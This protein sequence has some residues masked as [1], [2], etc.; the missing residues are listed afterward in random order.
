MRKQL[1]RIPLK[2]AL[3]QR[4]EKEIKRIINVQATIPIDLSTPLVLLT[5]A[6]GWLGRRIVAALRGGLPE[7]KLVLKEG[8]RLRALVLAREDVS[9]L[10]KQ[11]VEIVTGDIVDMEAVHAF[12]A[13]ADG[14]I[15]IHMAGVI[16]PK[17]VSQF[18]AINT[19]GT[20]NLI[21]AAQKT[22]VRR[23]VVISSNSPVGCNPHPDHRFTEESPYNPY[24]AYGRSKML[25]E[26]ALRTEIT[27]GSPMEIVIVRAP[28]FYG[29]G[30][31]SRQTLFF[32]MIKDGK[33]PIVGSGRNRRSMGYTDNL[34]QGIVLAAAHKDAAG[35]I[36]WLAD[37][38]PY[39]MNEIVETV[40]KV[41]NE[42]FGMTVK[43]N[44]I[45]LPSAAAE[46][47]TMVDASLQYVGIYHQNIHIFSEM[48]KTI[49]CDITKA[50]KVLGYAPN[51]AL[52]E[53]MRLS[54]ASCLK[55]GQAI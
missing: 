36:F 9:H 15:L 11:G 6:T 28:W 26:K 14:A 3:D 34:V 16:H 52:Q 20:I 55:T 25:M 12:M 33:F 49:A 30:Q 48:N 31:P 8:F 53:G 37:D 5:G 1:S 4:Q 43:P 44:T 50:K 17:I 42:D 54:I 45:R 10:R 19:Q 47:A 39:T 7:A 41:L 2:N 46:I 35:E 21:T 40:G 29:P 38:T 32:R 13:G 51:I 18:E 23:A 24:M 22:G 27:A